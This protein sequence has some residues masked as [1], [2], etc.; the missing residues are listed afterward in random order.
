MKKS[1]K[2]YYRFGLTLFIS[3]SAVILFYY[4]I[5]YGESLSQVKDA[6]IRVLLPIIDGI[7][8]AYVLS[9]LQNMGIK[10]TNK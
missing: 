7:A 4:V 8:I 3:L 10:N 1:N 9:P 6:V 5:F 2:K